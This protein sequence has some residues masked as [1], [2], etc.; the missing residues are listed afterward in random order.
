[1]FRD[2]IQFWRKMSV[3]RRRE[4]IFGGLTT[5]RRLTLSANCFGKEKIFKILYI[6]TYYMLN[7]CQILDPWWY[8]TLVHNLAKMPHCEIPARQNGDFGRNFTHFPPMVP[9]P[10]FFRPHFADYLFLGQT[11]RWTWTLESC[12]FPWQK[13]SWLQIIQLALE[14]TKSTVSINTKG[15][16]MS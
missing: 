2:S 6:L 15:L 4:A 3:K 9:H 7:E 13:A 11:D 16:Q 1:M 14:A 12:T 8:P 5:R 10:P